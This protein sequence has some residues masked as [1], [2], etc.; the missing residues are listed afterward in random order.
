M[1]SM[2]DAVII[3]T[4][5]SG[6]L[7]AESVHAAAVHEGA[8]AVH[9][10]N[11][12]VAAAEA[13]VAAEA[14]VAAV[15]AVSDIGSRAELAAADAGGAA[16]SAEAGLLAVLAA[17]EAQNALTSELLEEVRAARTP[18][19]VPEKSKPS[20]PDRAPADAGSSTKS[21]RR[22]PLASRYY[23]GRK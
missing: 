16:Q 21:S 12:S 14:S 1:V 2:A 23:G 11:A 15:G 5:E 17:I 18:P 20:T 8:A 13:A 19:P 9:E 7:D 3:P 4:S 10:Q 22:G 6:S